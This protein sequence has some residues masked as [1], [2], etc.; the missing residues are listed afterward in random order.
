MAAYAPRKTLNQRIEKLLDDIVVLGSIVEQA[1][2]QAVET[3]KKR[4][5]E[6]ALRIY[7]SDIRVNEKHYQIERDCLILIA[8]QQPL[9]IDLRML[10]SILKVSTELERI[11]D[12]AKGIARMTMQ[13]GQHPAISFPE[14]LAK[15]AL[16][17]VYMLQRALSAFI[18][19]DEASA[20]IIP[21]MDAEVDAYYNRINRSLMEMIG[22][23]PATNNSATVF[24]ATGKQI[25]LDISD[26][27][28]T[29][30]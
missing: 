20:R 24:V 18:E 12:Y 21:D 25:Q 28:I 19:M 10:A 7:A 16:C 9:A 8:T 6:T 13:T 17:S 5:A 2:L 4:D 3:L 11:G 27:K 30:E 23:N 14:E 29:V 15:M 22:Q 1:M 26:R